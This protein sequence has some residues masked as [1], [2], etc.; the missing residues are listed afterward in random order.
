MQI[1]IFIIIA[2][3]IIIIGYKLQKTKKKPSR[4]RLLQNVHGIKCDICHNNYTAVAV[5]DAFEEMYVCK[6]C[7]KCGIN[8][9]DNRYV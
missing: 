7:L 3:V 8:H 4:I 9:I 6:K 2:I 5:Y 1:I